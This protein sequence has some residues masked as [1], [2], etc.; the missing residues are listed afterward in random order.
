MKLPP[1]GD[2]AVA[3]TRAAPATRAAVVATATCLVVLA[4]LGAGISAGFGPQLRLDAAV[5]EA[6][7]AGDS[8]VGALDGLLE[9]LTAPGLSWV[10]FLVFLPVLVS[11]ARR[12]MWWTAGWVLTAVVLVAPLTTALKEYFGRIRPPFGEGGARYESLSFPSGHSSGIATLVAV[13][14]VLA[15]PLLSARA[16]RWALAVGIA[17]V[18]LVGLTRLWLGVHYLSDVVGGW[19]L[20]LAWTL[21]TALLFGAL[22]GGRAALR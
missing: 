6:L 3:R 17:L 18:V 10:R 11:L 21:G 12:R 19:S 14:L 16:R 22:P 15:W 20:G 13:A 7:Y 4:L 1:D 8:R 5:S 2:A 9:V